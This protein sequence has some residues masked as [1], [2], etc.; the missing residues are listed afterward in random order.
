[1]KILEE[2]PELF[3]LSGS[4]LSGFVMAL[5]RSGGFTRKN[6]RMRLAEACMCSMLSSAITMGAHAYG[7]SYEW[8]IPIG[9]FTGFIGT[10]IIR[11]FL[12]GIIEWLKLK[13]PRLFGKDHSN[14]NY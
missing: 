12:A 4:G 3:Y 5:L 1:M 7:F 8:A 14:E 9:T 10:D 6:L 2:H 13:Y 11:A